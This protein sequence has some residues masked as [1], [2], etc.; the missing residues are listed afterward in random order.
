MSSA[1]VVFLFVFIILV[2][3]A[4][5]IIFLILYNILVRRE[6]LTNA[7]WFEIGNLYQRKFD[8]IPALLGVAEKYSVHEK[9]ILNNVSSA[10]SDVKD[11]WLACQEATSLNKD[12][13][14]V[15]EQLYE[16]LKKSLSKLKIII[17][18]YPDLKAD[19]QYSS[20]QAQ[21]TNTEDG[22]AKARSKYNNRVNIYNT[23][24][25]IFPVNI[26]AILFKFQPKEY[27]E[28]ESGKE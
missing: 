11:V 18:N 28:K 25:R 8:L 14:Q 15:L 4:I 22:I 13:I 19:S 23:V 9:E 17:E 24:L 27:F 10:R 7:S 2:I 20:L 26:V 3:C 16:A 6:E 1:G 5:S 12:G 21:I